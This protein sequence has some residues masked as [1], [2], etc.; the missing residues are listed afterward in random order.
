MRYDDS[1][2]EGTGGE[3]EKEAGF[4]NWAKRE[5]VGPDD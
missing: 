2:N 3:N 1:P 4:S 5:A